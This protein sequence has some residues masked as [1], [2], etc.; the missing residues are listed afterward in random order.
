MT[1]PLDPRIHAVRPDL[2]DARLEGRATAAR[3]VA[4]RPARVAGETAPVRGRPDES[5]PWTSELLHGEAVTVFDAAD[6]WAWCQ[7]R[8]DSY[9]GYV[10]LACLA[11]GEAAPPSHVVAAARTLVFPEPSIKAP[12]RLA[13]S[14]GTRVAAAVHDATFLAIAG[15]FVVAR[16]LAPADATEP[17]LVATAERLLGVPYRWGGRSALGIDCSALAQLAAVRAGHACPRDSDQQAGTLGACVARA[18]PG[19]FLDAAALD[20]R[21]GDLLYSPGHVVIHAGDGEVVHA[22][23]WHMAVAREP[24]AALAA[25]L[26]GRGEGFTRQRRLETGGCPTA[27]T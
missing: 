21:R 13:L 7:N 25:R 10:P 3:F 20:A 2:A 9:V 16:H 14:L 6:G 4:G 26:A 1:L 19:S 23:A 5:A 18:D 8:A 17:D 24:L 15:G 11:D 22:N 27:A 12:S